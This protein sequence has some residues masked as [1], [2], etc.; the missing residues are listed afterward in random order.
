MQMQLMFPKQPS[1]LGSGIKYQV[2]CIKYQVSRNQIAG[3][4]CEKQQAANLRLCCLKKQ[5]PMHTNRMS[6]QS[7]LQNTV[8]LMWD[9]AIRMIVASILPT[10]TAGSP[11]GMVLSSDTG[12]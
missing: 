1:L 9:F 2:S 12:S 3:I 11:Q 5:M 4:M 10:T 8:A 6:S 7:V